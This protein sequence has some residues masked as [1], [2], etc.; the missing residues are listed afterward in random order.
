MSERFSNPKK[1]NIL[2]E[3]FEAT[4]NTYPEETARI[5]NKSKNKF[6]NPVGVATYESLESVIDILCQNMEQTENKDLD[7]ELIEQALDSVIRIRAVQNFSASKA[8]GFVFE[9]KDIVKKSAGNDITTL[10]DRKVDQ[11]A[12]AAFNRFLKCRESIFL[13]K[14]TEAKKRTYSAFERA[15]LVEEL[16]DEDILGS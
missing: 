7:E 10:F 13:L 1:K 6:D 3:W 11:I 5:L 12:L 16:K 14:A 9:L 4:I 8:V 15:G 2:Q